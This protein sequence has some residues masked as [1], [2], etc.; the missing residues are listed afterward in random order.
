MKWVSHKIITGATIYAF[1]G[2]V[3]A[4]I[5]SM[6]GSVIPDALEGMPDNTPNWRKYHRGITHWFVPYL[7][8]H[9]FIRPEVVFKH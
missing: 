1:T 5:A 3:F 2:D 6:A 7:F 4:T 9:T 8:V